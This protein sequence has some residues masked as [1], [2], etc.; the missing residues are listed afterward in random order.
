MSMLEKVRDYFYQYS[1]IDEASTI[2]GDYVPE[3]PTNYSIIQLPMQNGGKLQ[4]FVGG[5]AVKQFVFAFMVKQYYS[6]QND[7]TMINFHN[8]KFFEDLEKWME[9]NNEAGTYPDIEGTQRMEVLQTGFLFDVDGN[10]QY[11]SYQ[12]TARVIYYQERT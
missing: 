8:S 2:Y 5:D 4:S 9:A 1:G 12:M 7:A 10:G 11:A 3:E 6:I